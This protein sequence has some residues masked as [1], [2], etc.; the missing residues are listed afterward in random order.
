MRA[1]DATLKA[2]IE[3]A[4]QTLYN[5]ANPQM[6]VTVTRP[7]TPITRAG[8]WQESIVTAGAT[9]VCTSVCVRR[10]VKHPTRA[11]V[12][13]V[14]EGGTLV[15]KYADLVSVEFSKLQ[16]ITVETIAGCTACAVELDGFFR[17]VPRNRVEFLTDE[18]PWLFYVTAAGALMGGLLGGTYEVLVGANVTALDAIRGEA[19]YHKDE[20]QGLLLFYI[21]NGGVYYRQLIAGVWGG[22]STVTLAPANAVKIKAE[23]VFDWRI[24]LQVTEAGGALYE[25]FAKM[26]ASGWNGTEF[27][28][29]SVSGSG[30]MFDI[31]YYD[32]FNEENVSLDISGFGDLLYN[33]SPVMLRA[34]NLANVD[35]DFGYK[36]RVIWDEDLNLVSGN[37][38]AFSMVDST[39]A[40]FG[41][42]AITVISSREL[43]LDMQN[44]NNAVGAVTLSYDPGTMMGDIVAVTACDVAFTPTGLVPFA[45]DPPVPLSVINTIEWEAG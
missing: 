11:Y 39:L 41:C 40:V 10:Q 17:P 3:L 21:I 45:V 9:S 8:F 34:Y 30:Q 1:I 20:D 33:L 24:V 44:F 27:L 7:R 16:W 38:T 13:Y 6:D 15:V 28:Q 5:N 37:E 19:S 43:E 31:Y 25:I 14:T 23:R 35:E 12:A 22:Q 2:R 18:T 26:Q 32:F 29:F 36:I 4:Q 42:T